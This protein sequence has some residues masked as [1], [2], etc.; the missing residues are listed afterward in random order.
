[1]QSICYSE[2][3]IGVLEKAG[4]VRTQNFRP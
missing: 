2:N 3:E 1:L 4:V